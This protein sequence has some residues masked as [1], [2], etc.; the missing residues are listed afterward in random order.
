[1][2][3]RD[4]KTLARYIR[5]A[6]DA[7]ELRDWTFDLMR[8]PSEEDAYAMVWP[9]YGQRNARIAFCAN[10]RDLEPELQ[11]GTVVHELIHCHL[12][13]LQSQMENDLDGHLSS[14]A[15]SLFFR[16][17]RRNLEYAVDGLERAI[18]P[19]LPLIDWPV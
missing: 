16:S 5:Q 2:K 1:M 17:V 18:A 8:K 13:A 12:A 4:R 3:K 14:V 7:L 15:E 6:A 11:R 9:T 10:F 19:C